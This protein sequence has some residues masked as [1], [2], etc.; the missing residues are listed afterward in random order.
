MENGLRRTGVPF[1]ASLAGEDICMNLALYQKENL[2]E[3]VKAALKQTNLLCIV[4]TY[5]LFLTPI[6]LLLTQWWLSNNTRG[7]IKRRS[8]GSK[9]L[10]NNHW[11]ESEFLCFL[12]FYVVAAC[13]YKQGLAKRFWF[14]MKKVSFIPVLSYSWNTIVWSKLNATTHQKTSNSKLHLFFQC[15]ENNVKEWCN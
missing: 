9:Y 15:K 2:K 13:V 3:K 7:Y 1:L 12:T 8:P 14:N 4:M 10:F 5:P 6:K 11:N